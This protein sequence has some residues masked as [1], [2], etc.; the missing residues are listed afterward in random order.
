MLWHFIVDEWQLQVMA[1]LLLKILCC[2]VVRK[3]GEPGGRVALLS[4]ADRFVAVNL[5]AP[6]RLSI[7]SNSFSRGFSI[8]RAVYSPTLI[9]LSSGKI[10]VLSLIYFHCQMDYKLSGH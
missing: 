8:L 3:L 2:Q 5:R 4:A 9:A 7:C 1:V 10:E 6:T